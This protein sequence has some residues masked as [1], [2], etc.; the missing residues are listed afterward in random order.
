MFYF[1]FVLVV[2]WL[3][4]SSILGF[5]YALCRWGS[6][7]INQS[8]GRIFSWGV[9]KI[10]KIRVVVEGLEY[11]E[12]AQPCIYI[13]NHQSNLDMATYGFFYPKKTVVIG[14][15]E[16]RWMP[17]FGLFFV[18][19]GNILID[20]KKTT[21]AVAGL[22]Q[23]VEMIRKNSVSV[24]IFPEGTRNRSGQG[25]LPFKRGA[26]HMAV[27]AQIPIVSIISGPLEPLVS[28]RDRQVR[29]GTLKV[30]VLPPVETVGLTSDQIE[31]F[32]QGIRSRMLEAL[33]SVRR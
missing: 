19:A 30:R 7:E 28:I 1:Q 21:K 13:A 22:V 8:F 2:F 15:K 12:A 6:F 25:L 3:I 11:L 17:L 16:L 24:W 27:Q 23:V 31:D 33:P 9:L 10:L 18:A 32:A 14:K 4:I 29:G 26:F 5:I 20:R